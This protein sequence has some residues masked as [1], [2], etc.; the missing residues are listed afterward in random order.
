[1]I[2]QLQ[3]T[4]NKL[5]DCVLYSQDNH[6]NILQLGHNI[7][8]RQI[9]LQVPLTY[10]PIILADQAKESPFQR[11]N[12]RSTLQLALSLTFDAIQYNCSSLLDEVLIFHAE[13]VHQNFEEERELDSLEVAN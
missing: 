11:R 5:I 1:M 12:Q 9:P 2:Q 7:M 4:I 13:M 6:A 10:F 8:E 3:Y